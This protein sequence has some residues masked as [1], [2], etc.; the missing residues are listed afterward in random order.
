MGKSS[1][2][3][4]FRFRVR[5]TFRTQKNAERLTLSNAI[6]DLEETAL[7]GNLDRTGIGRV[8]RYQT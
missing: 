2:K 7:Q 6:F 1:G 4:H 5:P 8:D 3:A